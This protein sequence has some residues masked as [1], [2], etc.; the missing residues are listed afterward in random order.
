MDFAERAARNEEVVRDVN[1]Q[2]EEGAE[3]HGVESP[4]PFHCECGQT[5]CLEK[6]DLPPSLYERI[7]ANRYRFIVVP[8]H[9]QPEVERVVEEQEKFLIVEKIGEAREQID[10]DHPQQLHRSSDDQA[11]D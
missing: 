9:V 5:P 7:L 1:K 6:V 10:E 2:I 11:T 3:L 8:G 4:M